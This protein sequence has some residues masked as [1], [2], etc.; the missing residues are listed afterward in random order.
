MEVRSGVEWC[1]PTPCKVILEISNPSTGENDLQP[2][3][4][5]ESLL[6]TNLI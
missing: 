5:L 2:S 6:I 4:E 3:L 1:F